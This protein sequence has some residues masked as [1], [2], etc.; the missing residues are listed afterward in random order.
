MLVLT[1]A[2]AVMSC[3]AATPP[4]TADF[5]VPV[6]AGRITHDCSGK[7]P[8]VMCMQGRK[9]LIQVLLDHAT[10]FSYKA[11]FFNLRQEAPNQPQILFDAGRELIPAIRVA[12]Q[13]LPVQ[14]PSTATFDGSLTLTYPA[15]AGVVTTRKVY[16]STTKDLVVEEWHLRN[17]TDKPV[18]VS[19]ASARK[20]NSNME[21][22]A[23]VWTC[24][25]VPATSLQPGAVLSF[26]TSL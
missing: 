21:K 11:R 19:V 6:K 14:W 20:V 12:D 5:W 15:G 16:P 24:Q 25:G 8:L 9:V 2:A 22:F 17:T 13:P 18:R 7:D 4:A 1:T 23:I 3:L 26:A 10:G